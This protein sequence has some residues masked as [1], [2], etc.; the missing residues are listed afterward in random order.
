MLRVPTRCRF[1]GFRCARLIAVLVRNRRRSRPR[2]V[3]T[4]S[5]RDLEGPRSDRPRDR[6][7]SKT[8]R[9]SHCRHRFETN[10][11]APRPCRSP[12]S[13]SN[14]G[15]PDRPGQVGGPASQ[16]PRGP[17]ARTI[18]RATSLRSRFPAW[19][20]PLPTPGCGPRTRRAIQGKRARSNGVGNARKF[21][22]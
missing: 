22:R 11:R 17:I 1:D 19:G 9:T 3:G 21:R 4:A 5:P 20:C 18:W 10:G 14:E 13:S 2:I 7:S 6:P 15:N 8:G 16:G 12:A